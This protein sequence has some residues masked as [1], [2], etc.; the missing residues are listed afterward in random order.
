MTAMVSPEDY[1]RVMQFKWSV[2]FIKGTPYASRGARKPDGRQSILYM[3]RFLIEPAPGQHVDHA[4]RDSLDNRRSNIRIATR[5][6]NMANRG[7]QSRNS[8]GFIGVFPTK[9]RFQA[10]V[11]YLGREIYVGTFDLAVDAARAR[12]RTALE[13]F[14]D[15]AVL[16]FPLPLP[17]QTPLAVAA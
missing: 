11:G 2:S 14:Q 16:N 6:Q 10:A 5:S 1:D 9:G 12:D 4:N 17:V 15:F 13:L 3:H 7:L 8:S